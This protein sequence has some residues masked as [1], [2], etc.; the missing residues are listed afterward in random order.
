MARIAVSTPV[1]YAR[2]VIEQTRAA[3][4]I[5]PVSTGEVARRARHGYVSRRMLHSARVP[6]QAS[7]CPAFAHSW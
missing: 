5:A 2:L 4:R 1:E 3:W 7:N 6:V